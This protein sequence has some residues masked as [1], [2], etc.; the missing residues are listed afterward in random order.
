[1]AEY[2]ARSILSGASLIN[3]VNTLS[4]ISNT[5]LKKPFSFDHSSKYSRLRDERQ[6]TA[7]RS[8]FVGSI[9]SEHRLD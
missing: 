2:L 7:V 8:L 9:I 4:S 3:I 6:H 5:S 1:M